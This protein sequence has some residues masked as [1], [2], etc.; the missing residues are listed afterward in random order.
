LCGRIFCYD[1]SKYRQRIPKDLLSKDSQAPTWNDF[2]TTTN[3]EEK[4]VC[5]HCNDMIFRINKVKK[6]IGA[7]SAVELDALELQ[8]AKDKCESWK[9]AANFC[10]SKLSDIQNKLIFQ[11]YTEFEKKLLWLN[12]KYFHGHSKYTLALLKVCKNDEDV[13][14]VINIIE[15]KDGKKMT[16]HMD[17]RCKRSCSEVIH[18]M[19][20]FNL[21][22]VCFNRK[23]NCELLKKVAFKHLICSDK[24]FQ[25]Y[26]SS[27]VYHIKFDDT[28]LLTSELIKRCTRSFELLNS[29]FLELQNYINEEDHSSKYREAYDKIVKFYSGKQHQNTFVKLLEGQTFID[30]IK[31]I[32]RAICDNGKTYDEVRD[33]FK[34]NKELVYPLDIK[35]KIKDININGIKFKNSATNPIII[36]CETTTGTCTKLMYKK[37]NLRKD[38]V[39]MNLIK[40]INIIVKREEG[41]DLNLVTYN[42]LPISRDSGIIEIVDKADTIYYIREK[43]Q[44]TILN[45]M[46]EKNHRMKI[47]DFKDTYIKSAA[48]YSVITY[49]FGIG[50]RH[51]DNIMITRDARMFHI[52][53]GFILGK[54]PVFSDPGIRIT[55]DMIEAIGGLSSVYYEEFTN[56]STK[57]YNALRRNIDVFMNMLLILPKL[58]TIDIDENEIINQ[59]MKRFLPGE[60]DVNA[61][62]HLVKKLESHNYTDRIKDWCHYHTK[63]KTV[64]SSLTRLGVAISSLSGLWNYEVNNA[65]SYI[66]LDKDCVEEE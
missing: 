8:K 50:D 52:D 66:D 30:I 33:D 34:L 23:D 51:L 26:I 20:A 39:I 25:C 11:K 1:C 59:V 16:N 48:A 44:S 10:L 12:S 65:Y 64:S 24:E 5:A 15:N 41:I 31:K 21:L 53:F 42:I 29:L 6:I 63:E 3:Y 38:Q 36:P 35:K 43:M 14:K 28:G 57:I 61:T 9:F 47:G 2:F 55:P 54:D 45:Y 32:G 62:F 46:L 58:T 4:R 49:L 13:K 19:D 40:L 27:L 56:L 37:E 60:N 22:I 18:S 17:I 7:F